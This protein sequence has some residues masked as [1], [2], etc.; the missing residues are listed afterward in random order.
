M[1]THLHFKLSLPHKNL[2]FK[3]KIDYKRGTEWAG[4]RLE[5]KVQTLNAYSPISK[6]SVSAYLSRISDSSSL[7]ST[8]T[9]EKL[10]N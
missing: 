7:Q 5:N 10:S 9:I 3:D 4:L 8:K 6:N 1:I 2:F